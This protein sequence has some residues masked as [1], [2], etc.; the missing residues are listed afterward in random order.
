MVDVSVVICGLPQSGK[1]TFLAALWHVI[2]AREIVT[3]L[4]FRTLRDGDA[5]HLNALADRWRSG[6]EQ[7]R[8][9]LTAGRQVSMSLLDE[10]Q[11]DIRVTFPD[12][13]GEIYDRM[14]ERRECDET[15][16]AMLKS[17]VG[18]LLFVH[19]DEIQAPEWIVNHA[20]LAKRLGI[21]YKAGE[22]IPW[23]P[24]LSPT[25]VKLIGLLEL[26]KQKPI[27]SQARKLAIMLSAWDKVADEGLEP[28]VFLAT[29]LPLLYQYLSHE[30]DGWSWS[31]FGISAQGGAYEPEAGSP[32]PLSA[33]ERTHLNELR[34]KDSPSTRI[35]VVSGAEETHDLTEP[36]AWVK[37]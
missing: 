28:K 34:K 17:S 4:S 20:S 16:L 5:T 2:T 13:S 31:V 33:E 35:K 37:R 11:A 22:P 1:S 3:R 36:I 12:I 6:R 10:G 24:K 26:L 27:A 9:A 8:T 15:T 30:A 32:R 25:Q 29:R 7:A 21:P 23:H 14:W 19:A 18:L